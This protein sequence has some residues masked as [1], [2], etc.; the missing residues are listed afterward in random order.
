MRLIKDKSKVKSIWDCYDQLEFLKMTNDFYI[1]RK[2]TVLENYNGFAKGDVDQKLL[3]GFYTSGLVENFADNFA[4]YSK[5][6][7]ETIVTLDKK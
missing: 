7:E 6:I 2:V 4:K 3:F 1:Q 5:Y